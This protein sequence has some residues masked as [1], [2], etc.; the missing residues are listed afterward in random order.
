MS[1]KY[2]TA[3]TSTVVA[4]GVVPLYD[5]DYMSI[6]ITGLSAETVSLTGSVD[7]GVTYSTTNIA[8]AA[9][10]TPTTIIT[11]LTNATYFLPWMGACPFT[12]IKI[13]KSA[14]VSTVVCQILLS[15]V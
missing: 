10:A 8:C 1:K 6:N 7:G 15:K 2:K 3:L 4:V 11:A 9:I 14:G 5:N 13:T 12:H